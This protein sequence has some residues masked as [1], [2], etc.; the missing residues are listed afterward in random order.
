METISPEAQILAALNRDSL[1]GGHAVLSALSIVSA[2]EW[3]LATAGRAGVLPFNL[4]VAFIDFNNPPRERYQPKTLADVPA[5]LVWEP[6]RLLIPN[7]E[8]VDE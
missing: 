5:G 7:P 3:W 2:S 1:M 8:S 6:V 4:D